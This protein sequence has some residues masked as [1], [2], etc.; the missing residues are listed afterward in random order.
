MHV[1]RTL[2]YEAMLIGVSVRSQERFGLGFAYYLQE[3][4][5]DVSGMMEGGKML[6]STVLRAQITPAAFYIGL[7]PAGCH[8]TRR[9]DVRRRHLSNV[10]PR[11]CLKNWKVDNKRKIE[12]LEKL[13]F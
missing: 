9:D 8:Y 5:I 10:R 3:Q 7:V 4:G 1:Y 11:N 13:D 2:V 12:F 6:M